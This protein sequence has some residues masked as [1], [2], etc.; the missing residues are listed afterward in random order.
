MEATKCWFNK[1]RSKSKA[2]AS[3]NETTGNGR[4]GSNGPT[5]VAPSVATK[6][7]VAAAKQYIE[8][9]YK[10]QMKNLQERRERYDPYASFYSVNL[11]LFLVVWSVCFVSSYL[12]LD[13]MTHHTL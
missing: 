4:E 2:K 1:F 7:K 8:K 3:R 9:H 6:Q 13:H 11:S 5:E 10:E 12:I